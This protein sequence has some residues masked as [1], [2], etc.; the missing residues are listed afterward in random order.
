VVVA[1]SGFAVDGNDVTGTVQSLETRGDGIAVLPSTFGSA[2]GATRITG[3]RVRDVGGRGIAVLAP[4]TSLEVTHNLVE[5]ALHGIVMD[6]RARADL[7]NVSDNTVTDTGSRES[8][9]SDGVIGIRVVGAY[10]AAVESNT[11]HGVG[12]A[13]EARGSSIGIDVLACVESRVAGN[14]VDRVGF[15][16]EGGE[17]LGI[18]VRGR[19][20]R[21]QVAGNSSRRQPVDVDEDG[22]SAFRGLLIGSEADPREPGA[23]AV[24]GYVVGT[25]PATFAI[26]AMAAFAAAFVPASVTVD[27]NIVSGGPK[28]SSTLIGVAG[29][30]VLTGNQ[31]HSGRDTDTPALRLLAL[32]ATVSANRFRGGK[33]SAELD[34]DP[35]RLAVLGNLTSTGITVFGSGLDPRWDPLNVNGI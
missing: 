22:P 4:V 15:P 17:D 6:E 1:A 27:T 24:K 2:R 9:K 11:V 14:S 21:S 13:L 35:E 33:P 31:L 3:N 26:G 18:A 19:V 12:A 20:I 25:G 30:V 7:A 28:L 10:R 32:A 16:E 8:D 29:E 5:R 23:T 34:V